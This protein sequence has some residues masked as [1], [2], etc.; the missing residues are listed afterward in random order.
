[1]SNRKNKRRLAIKE[2]KK[3]LLRPT[4]ESNYFIPFEE[5]D[6][7]HIKSKYGFKNIRLVNEMIYITTYNDEEFYIESDYNEG[8]KDFTSRLYHKNTKHNTDQY[9]E[10]T[11]YFANIFMIFGY[12][13]HHE[14]KPFDTKRT[15]Q[16][17]EMERMKEL[18]EQ[19]AT[20]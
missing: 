6:L 13:R 7:D 4:K 3:P 11:K 8:I 17:R 16:I 15:P 20:D 5:I 12:I 10:E 9:H 1:M 2:S 19:I 18:F 14:Q